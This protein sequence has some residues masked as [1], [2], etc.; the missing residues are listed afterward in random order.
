VSVGELQVSVE[1]GDGEI[2]CTIRGE[3]DMES[4]ERFTRAVEDACA[5]HEKA[6]VVIDGSGIEFCDSAG[7]RALLFA[8]NAADE[9]GRTFRIIEPSAQLRRVAEAA[10]IAD[11]LLDDA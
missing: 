6:A 2:R 10:V 3:L 1:A 11:F 4:C 9:A 5:R 8:R 7:L